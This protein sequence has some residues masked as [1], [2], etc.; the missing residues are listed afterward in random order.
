MDIIFS[1]SV[2]NFDWNKILN[3][4]RTQIREEPKDFINDG[5]WDFLQPSGSEDGGGVGEGSE[6]GDSAFSVSEDDFVKKFLAIYL[7]NQLGRGK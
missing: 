2:V 5:G 7:K 3:E 1:E 4:V 6:A